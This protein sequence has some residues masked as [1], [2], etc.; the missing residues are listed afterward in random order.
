MYAPI[1]GFTHLRVYVPPDPVRY[2]RAT[3]SDED[4]TRRR[5]LELVHIVLEV[6][7]GLRPLTHLN[8]DR[9]SAAV[10]L[11]IRAWSRGRSQRAIGCQ[12]LSLHCQP[13][14]EYFGSASMGSNRHAFTGRY[15]GEALTSFRLI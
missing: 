6:A 2:N 13:S 10:M 4:R 14:G 1:P 9:F 5:T 8:N 3:P 15:D 12:L 11:H 7:A